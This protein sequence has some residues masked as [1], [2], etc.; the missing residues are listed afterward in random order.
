MTQ[1]DQEQVLKELYELETK[2][3]ALVHFT[4]T[5]AYALLAREEQHRLVRQMGYM[6][7]Y[8]DVLRERI[9]AFA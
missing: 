9:E 3:E 4:A 8:K 7:L 6:I 2:L 5:M 1:A